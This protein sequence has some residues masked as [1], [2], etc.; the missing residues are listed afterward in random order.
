VTVAAELIVNIKGR[1]LNLMPMIA[2]LE[3]RLKALEAAGTKA[4]PGFSD[5]LN[6]GARQAAGGMLALQ[7]AQARLEAQQGNLV[8]AANRLRTAL[9]ATTTTTTQTIAARRQLLAVEQ[10]L[11]TGQSG[12]ARAFTEAGNAA[13]SSLTS[14]IGPAA[15]VTGGLAAA[16]AVVNSFAAAFKFKADLDATTASINAQLKGVRDTGTVYAQASAFANTYKLTQQETTQAIA[17]SI[18]VMRASKASVEDILSVLARLQVLSPEQSLQEAAIAIKALASGDTTSLVTRF[19]VG[20]DVAAQMKQEIAG[21]ADAVA[22]MNTFLLNTGIG[23]DALAAKTT[24]AAGALKDVAIAQ[25]QLSLAQAKFAEGPGMLVLIEQTQV[26]SGLTR[27][28]TGDTQAMAISALQAQAAQAGAAGD[29]QSQAEIL[30][31]LAQHQQFVSNSALGLAAASAQAASA[32]TGLTGAFDQERQAIGQAQVALEQQI[33]AMNADAAQALITEANT[34]TLALRKVELAFQAQQAAQALLNSGAAGAAAATRLAGSSS[35]VDQLTAAYFRLAQAQQAAGSGVTAAQGVQ[36]HTN[37]LEAQAN[38]YKKIRDAQEQQTLSIGTAAQ[39][40]AVLNARLERARVTQGQLS[41][42][43]IR[44]DTELKRFQATQAKAPKGG[45]GGGS[46]GVKLSDQQKLNTQLL[47]DQE[48]FQDK[49]EDLELKHGLKLLSIERDANEKR[50]AA[51]QAFQQ[52]RLDLDK[53]FYR[54]IGDIQDNG[55]QRIADAQWQQALADSEEIGRTKGRDAGE[56]YLEARKAAILVDAKN[57][58]EINKALAEGDT[59]R[60]EFLTAL[61]EKDRVAAAN[62]LRQI[63]ENGSAIENERARQ[64]AEEERAYEESQGR[65]ADQAETSAARRIAA[66]ERAGKAI[67]PERLAVQSLT[68]DYERLA[69]AAG[70]RGAPAGATTGAAP[71]ATTTPTSPTEGA[72]PADLAAL[73]ASWQAI[74]TQITQAIAANERAVREGSSQV[75]SA[76]GGRALV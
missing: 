59:G 30:A 46:G 4:G 35:L 5:P 15:L 27:I 2:A 56:A 42:E 19:E 54:S 53:S 43:Y 66:N 17:A 40:Q 70:S 18:G 1:D 49:S 57:Q 62:R 60:A 44:A 63:E 67:D 76:V 23:M 32:A 75:A 74:G 6:R 28:L 69:R 22:V 65:V 72:A 34:Q 68:T 45:G 24:G 26:L 31:I 41:V 55:I 12:L 9:A 3:A 16:T 33:Q 20:R 38:A 39:Q 10:Q 13:R 8:G 14:M 61:Q 48:K 25:E 47:A 11:A 52:S 50:R 64:I 36:Q 71:A 51:A 73:L 37:R 7:Q 58:E 21:G 29:F